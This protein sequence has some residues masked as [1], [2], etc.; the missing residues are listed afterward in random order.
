MKKLFSTMFA[1]ALVMSMAMFTSCSGT[2]S[3]E[4]V[5][6]IIKEAAKDRTLTADDYKTLVR[7]CDA[8]LDKLAALQEK[9]DKAREEG[10]EADL[11]EYYGQ[12]DYLMENDFKH[13]NAAMRIIMWTDDDELGDALDKVKQFREKYDELD[14]KFK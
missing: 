8:G 5:A 2:P 10:N 7:Y 14:K 12:G 6:K 1:F 4:E 11:T 3:N 13:Y 9:I